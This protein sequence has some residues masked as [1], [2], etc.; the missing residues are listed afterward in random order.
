MTRLHYK[1]PVDGLD[2]GRTAQRITVLPL[3]SRAVT[4]DLE[5]F[6]VELVTAHPDRLV[7]VVADGWCRDPRSALSWVR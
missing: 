6:E 2:T 4:S 1:E 5:P 3:A 7:V